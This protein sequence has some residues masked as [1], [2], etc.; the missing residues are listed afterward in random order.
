MVE[1]RTK[2]EQSIDGYS[3]GKRE[4]EANPSPTTAYHAGKEQGII[5]K[6]NTVCSQVREV[7]GTN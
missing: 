2:K 1:A 7:F 5:K 6:N 4:K 3:K